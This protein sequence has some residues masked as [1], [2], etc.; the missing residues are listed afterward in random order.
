ML[1]LSSPLSLEREPKHGSDP[2]FVEPLVL[3]RETYFHS[4][5]KRASA[6]SCPEREA[7][8]RERTVLLFW[9]VFVGFLAFANVPA[10][11]VTV[12]VFVAFWGGLDV[13]S[14]WW[15][16]GKSELLGRGTLRVVASLSLLLGESL[17]CSNLGLRFG[18]GLLI[19]GG[20]L[21]VGVL[22]LQ[23][24]GLGRA[25][26]AVVGKRSRVFLMDSMFALEQLRVDLLNLWSH[27][28]A[29]W[30]GRLLG[31]KESLRQTLDSSPC[32]SGHQIAQ[33]KA[34]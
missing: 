7:R 25:L 18:T 15:A 3:D 27:R 6:F 20:A 22:L 24:S 8:L 17:I 5:T 32:G 21:V 23:D 16:T 1:L 2:P 19:F 30:S 29:H 33:D 9:A 28:T 13:S 26:F 4:R 14:S 10:N 12:G 11:L 31:V 34:A